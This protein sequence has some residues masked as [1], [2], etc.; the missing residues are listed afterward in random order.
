M[1]AVVNQTRRAMENK[2]RMA[3][4]ALIQVILQEY[5]DR[6]VDSITGPTA[7]RKYEAATGRHRVWPGFASD[8]L[9]SKRDHVSSRRE[10]DSASFT[11]ARLLAPSGVAA[12]RRKPSKVKRTLLDGIPIACFNIGGEKRLCFDQ[13]ISEVL[14]EFTLSEV[15]NSRDFLKI[16]CPKCDE[17]QLE[18]L[19]LSKAVPWSDSSCLLITKSDAY[20]LCSALLAKK[21]P[22]RH[23]KKYTKPF[24][25]V[26]HECFGGCEGIFEPEIYNEPH[27]KCVTCLEC[28][29]M[30]SPRKFVTHSHATMEIQTCHW[31]MDSS[32]WRDYLL[33]PDDK[34]D[35]ELIKVG[36]LRFLVVLSICSHE[37]QCAAV[38]AVFTPS[39]SRW[40]LVFI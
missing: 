11:T 40:K 9:K 36:K 19:K 6:S 39:L 26:Y 38:N 31:G 23:D 2:A 13:L 30:F 17:D 27:A 5:R 3:D 25:E 1:S 33:L 14:K 29:R 32:K 24:L 34:A 4:K 10:L 12:V 21:A 20:R 35:D 37:M 8:I 7:I 18:S 15:N 16:Y 28:Y 22:Q